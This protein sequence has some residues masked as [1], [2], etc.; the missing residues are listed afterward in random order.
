VVMTASEAAIV[1][2]LIASMKRPPSL[3]NCK[4][5]NDLTASLQYSKQPYKSE[6]VESTGS[7]CT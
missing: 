4:H 1:S 7:S 3:S 2:Q 6:S 5:C